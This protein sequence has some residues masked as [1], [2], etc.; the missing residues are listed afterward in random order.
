MSNP[1]LRLGFARETWFPPRACLLST[2]WGSG[3][4]ERG[5]THGSTASSLLEGAA[6]G[7][8]TPLHA[9]APTEVGP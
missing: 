2:M 6:G 9:H 8:P 5:A 3:G 7:F 4:F 1:R